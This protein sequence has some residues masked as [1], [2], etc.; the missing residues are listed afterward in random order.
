ME[1]L[2]H[3]I[4][5]RRTRL[6]RTTKPVDL[7]YVGGVLT[8]LPDSHAIEKVYQ[9]RCNGVARKL[10]DQQIKSLIKIGFYNDDTGFVMKGGRQAVT[11]TPCPQAS[12]FIATMIT[13]NGVYR[14]AGGHWILL[15]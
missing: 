9:L 10:T 3:F 11:Y 7:V 14:D 12:R 8:V 2:Y 4:L 5:R 13:V 1:W 6:N 15:A